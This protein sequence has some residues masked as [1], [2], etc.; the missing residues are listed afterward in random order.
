MSKEEPTITTINTI[1][2]EEV[3][4]LAS[5]GCK[6]DEIA[7]F[8]EVAEATIRKNFTPQL[9]KG[10]EKMKLNLRQLQWKHAEQGNT[11]LLIFLG[12]QYLGQSEKSEL[13]LTAS[14]EAILTECGYE[15][16]PQIEEAGSEPQKVLEPHRVQSKSESVKDS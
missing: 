6:T 1:P 14:M 16:A 3:E 2:S 5:F 12:K 8:F 11:A 7:R 9:K 10:K 15:D 4:M 13:D